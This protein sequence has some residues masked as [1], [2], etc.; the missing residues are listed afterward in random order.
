MRARE[1][2][3]PSAFEPSYNRL[4]AHPLTV[5]VTR[6]LFG[7]I[8]G[9]ASDGSMC[10][11]AASSAVL[12]GLDVTVDS[13][14]ALATGVDE[15]YSLD[16][17]APRAKLSANTTWGALA[18]MQSFIQLVQWTV[19]TTVGP[20]G[21]T[22]PAAASNDYCISGAPIA[23]QDEPRFAWRG[24]LMDTSRHFLHP[25]TIRRTLDAMAMNKMNHL[26]RSAPTAG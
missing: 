2:P 15:S 3:C 22:K 16:I 19:S 12:Q 13:Q 18:G 5:C 26:V 1:L 23:I 14:P 25:A 6:P 7:S 8:G 9:A 4:K 17:Q 20:D 24:L 21:Q 11:G 10:N